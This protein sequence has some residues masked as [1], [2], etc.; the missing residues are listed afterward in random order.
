MPSE[1][2]SKSKC[3]NG[4]LCPRLLWIALNEAERVPEPDAATQ[5][6]FD[7]GH[8][9]GELGRHQCARAD[10]PLYEADFRAVSSAI[11]NADLDALNRGVL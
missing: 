11:P 4:L 1:L 3:S 5:H 6:I 10:D 2:L 8:L 9:V 7:Q